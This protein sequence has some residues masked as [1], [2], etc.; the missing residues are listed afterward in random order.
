MNEPA[1][2][3]QTQTQPTSQ[4]RLFL[5]RRSYQRRR[6]IDALRMLPFLGVL[7]WFVPLVWAR[8]SDAGGGGGVSVVTASIFIFAVWAALATLSAVLVSRLTDEDALQAPPH[9]DE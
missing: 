4:P 5:E 8:A 1:R 7:L 6:L 9:R 2:Q 3:T